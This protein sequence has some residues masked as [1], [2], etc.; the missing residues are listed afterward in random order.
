M[1]LALPASASAPWL[2]P[3]LWL[4]AR[5]TVLLVLAG[6]AAFAL[7]RASAAARHLAWGLAVAGML[8]LP[9]VSLAAP[10]WELPWVRLVSVDAPMAASTAVRAVQEDAGMPWGTMVLL[11]W[12]AGAALV[13]ARYAVAV[14][15]VRLIARRATPLTEGEWMRRVRE[16]AR[17]L[18][19]RE[20]VRL[21]RAED[22][23]MPMTWGILRPVVL[24]PAEADAWTEQRKRVVLLHEMAHVAR[25]DCLW[26]TLVRLACAAYWFHPGAWWAARQM[27]VEREQACDDRVLAA[28]TRPSEY[29]GHLLEVARSFR[30]GP[31]TAAAAVAMARP[32]QLEG[33]VVAVLD[34]ARSRGRVPVRVALLSSGVAAVVLFPLA[35]AS[36]DGFEP[37][38]APAPVREPV[39]V[40][41]SAPLE[42]SVEAAPAQEKG[43]VSVPLAGAGEMR[44]NVRTPRA[45]PRPAARADHPYPEPFP[46]VA[47][48][49]GTLAALMRATYDVDP[50]VRRS[51]VWALGRMDGGAV[52]NSLVR[53][54][55]DAD[56]RVRSAAALALGEYAERQESTR[57][58]A[59]RRAGGDSLRVPTGSAPAAGKP[60][61]AARTDLVSGGPSDPGLRILAGLVEEDTLPSS[62]SAEQL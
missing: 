20:P 45:A 23:A 61:R 53:S 11:A 16:A 41:A 40:A 9:A 34:A 27:H 57:V 56:A 4:V 32:S 26:Q 13:L 1:E 21:L 33:R 55:N 59:G 18:G 6:A 12:M 3:A 47:M 39:A 22:A 43:A 37:P 14:L 8:A 29:A 54:M 58:A 30:P 19:M 7:R 25:R 62:P 10:A 51:A 31:L 24:I 5:G 38:P 60:P 28:G 44:L 35:A 50:E 49:Q 17:E 36:P 52:V 48:D 42:F 2:A 46:E 15:S